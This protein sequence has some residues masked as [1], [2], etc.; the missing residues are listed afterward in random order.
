MGPGVSA[1]HS[2]APWRGPSPSLPT[3]RVFFSPPESSPT[4]FPLFS[5]PF[6]PFSFSFSFSVSRSGSYG[7][8][9]SESRDRGLAGSHDRWGFGLTSPGLGPALPPA[10]G[11]TRVCTHTLRLLFSSA[12]SLAYPRSLSVCRR[13]E[14]SRAFND[15]RRFTADSGDTCGHLGTR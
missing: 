13:R 6:L 7:A 1:P 5:L 10:R 11:H 2:A 8:L 15:V 12:F 4:A 14:S 3:Q 9:R